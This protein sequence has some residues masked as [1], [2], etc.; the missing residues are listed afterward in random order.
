[1][2]LSNAGLGGA[3]YFARAAEDGRT[4]ALH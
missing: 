4:L 1:L 3:R 2:L